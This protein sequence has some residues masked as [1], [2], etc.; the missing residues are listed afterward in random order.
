MIVALAFTS[1]V[2]GHDHG[3]DESCTVGDLEHLCDS[4]KFL[5][6]S[7]SKCSCSSPAVYDFNGA[8]CAL[9]LG[10]DCPMNQDPNAPWCFANAFCKM[11]GTTHACTCNDGFVEASDK[12]SCNSGSKMYSVAVLLTTA[13]IFK[14]TF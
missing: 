11:T 10:N 13:F 8:K 4:T 14:M 6:C 1:F 7:G 2:S 3:Y 9:A 12:K 5:V